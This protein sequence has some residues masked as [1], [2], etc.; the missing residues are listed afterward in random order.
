MA[1]R[2][3]KKVPMGNAQ[4]Y[5]PWSEP[6][7]WIGL[8]VM[9][10]LWWIILPKAI[11]DVLAH[12]T[13]TATALGQQMA[14]SVAG[15]IVVAMLSRKRLGL[16]VSRGRVLGVLIFSLLW[17]YFLQGFEQDDAGVWRI[18]Y[19]EI[20]LSIVA[21]V[22]VAL[23][24]GE[25]IRLPGSRRW[26]RWSDPNDPKDREKVDRFRKQQERFDESRQNDPGSFG[27]SAWWKTTYHSPSE[28]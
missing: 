23:V 3:R 27:S 18:V 25:V 20:V 16:T 9:L 10:L 2:K 7:S 11:A 28:E 19:A 1:R 4:E 15:L 26:I 6:C 17:P 24:M 22:I 21:L 5:R 13:K 14:W 12:G 8:A